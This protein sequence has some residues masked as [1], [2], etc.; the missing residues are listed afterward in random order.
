MIKLFKPIDIASSVFFRIAFGLTAMVGS[1][2]YLLNGWVTELYVKPTFFFSYDGFTWIH[3]WP[4]PVM[5]GWYIALALLG[6]LIAL[7]CFYRLSIVLYFPGFTY[8][9]LIDKTAY[10]NHY[11]AISLL[12]FLMI[13]LPLHRAF[14]IDVWRKPAL[15]RDAIPAWCVWIIR[16]QL[17][18]IY[19][20]AGVA[21][22]NW[23]WLLRGEPLGI[24]LAT[25]TYLPGLGRLFALPHAG[26]VMSGM[27]ALFDLTI[28]FWL[29]FKPTRV[30]AYFIVVVFHI[31]TGLCFTIGMFPI[32][33][34]GLT[35]IFFDPS[36]PRLWS[37]SWRVP[38]ID[39][40]L[41]SKRQK[42]FTMIALTVY[43]AIQLTLPLRHFLY[44]GNV[45]WTEE[46]FR[47]SWLVMLV[48]KN[49]YVRFTI[50]DPANGKMY[51]AS[52][53]DYLTDRQRKLAGASPDML[54]QM[55]L[56]IAHEFKQRGVQDPEVYA[57]AWASMNERP[58]QRLIDPTVDLAKQKRGFKHSSWI[59]PLQPE[60]TA[61]R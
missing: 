52:L 19:F 29:L 3:A 2:R 31:V 42:F 55:A 61:M 39:D 17:G 60:V 50:K 30:W 44:P 49:G 27:G 48:E 35:P 56:H 8:V 40:T 34:I 36:W 12:S 10:L 58:E 24:W 37:R 1:L 5:Y 21:K 45:S 38:L 7:G 20:F 16:F 51:Q 6:A 9:E 32:I 53:E 25:N 28:V 14:S 13:F 23:D 22:L 46:G 33:M 15:R 4:A 57:D 26:H 41:I 18:C 54:L 47:F 59:L 11:Y 43:V